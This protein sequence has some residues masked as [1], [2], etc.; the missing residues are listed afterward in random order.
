M[1]QEMVKIREKISA[2][3]TIERLSTEGV[4]ERMIEKA[5]KERDER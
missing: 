2:Q 1:K 5:I 3:V 4:E